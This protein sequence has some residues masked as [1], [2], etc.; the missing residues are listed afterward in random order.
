MRKIFLKR[1]SNKRYYLTSEM[2]LIKQHYA[3]NSLLRKLF[4]RVNRGLLRA[5]NKLS[6]QLLSMY[7][8][9]ISRI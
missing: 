5:G 6:Q 2:N 8:F 7:P 4:L 1:I 9:R 3:N